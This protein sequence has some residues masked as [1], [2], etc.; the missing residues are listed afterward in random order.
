MAS[1]KQTIIGARLN[2]AFAVPA[3]MY[4]RGARNID[5]ERELQKI[6]CM[7]ILKAKIDKN[8]LSGSLTSKVKLL[9]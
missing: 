7:T 9:I 2:R 4:L 1:T 6:R 8:L 5:T 3:G